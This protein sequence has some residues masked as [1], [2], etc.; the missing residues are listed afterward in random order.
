[1]SKYKKT[2]PFKYNKISMNSGNNDNGNKDDAT[3][4]NSGNDDNGENNDK[5]IC[6]YISFISLVT[7]IISYQIYKKIKIIK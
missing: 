5:I 7:F 1:M 2:Y 6:F 4:D 3:D